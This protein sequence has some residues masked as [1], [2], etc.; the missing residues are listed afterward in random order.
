MLVATQALGASW[1]SEIYSAYIGNN[2]SRWKQVI[3]NMEISGEKTDSF[4]LELVNYQYGY[5]AWCLGNNREEEAKQYLDK[6][7]SVLET[8]RSDSRHLSIVHAYKSAF[9]GYRIALARIAAPLLGP[10]SIES[11]R[12][13][14]RLD[15]GNYLG[16]VQL[17]NIEFY[18]PSVFGGSKKEA[19]EH[20]LIAEKLLAGTSGPK[21]PDWNYLSLL[22]VIAQSYTYT[23][24]LQS[25]K[26]YLELILRVE[27][28]FLWVKNEL[29]PQ[30]IDKMKQ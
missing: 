1:R 20:Y 26:K 16:Y 15:P 13:A 17:G 19:L 4:L 6:A 8:L 18:M 7:E 21:L 29:Y 2:M 30:V 27:P 5:I 25:A 23:G 3:D 9:Y 14:V 10:R 12:E 11:A 24:D 28:E 22:T